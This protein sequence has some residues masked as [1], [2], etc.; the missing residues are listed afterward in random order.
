MPRNCTICRHPERRDIDA[1]LKA[2][3][4]YRAIAQRYSISKDAVSLHRRHIPPQT[5]PALVTATKIVAF[6]DDAETS[7]NFNVCLRMVQE[8]R[9]CLKELVTQL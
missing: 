3:M 9:R 1:D 5:R 7:A 6:L 4:P 2:G 8:A